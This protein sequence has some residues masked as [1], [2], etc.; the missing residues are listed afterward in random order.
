[1]TATTKRGVVLCHPHPQYGGDMHNPVVLA[2]AAALQDAGVATLRFN[3]RGVGASEGDYAGGRGEADDARGAVE[4]LRRRVGA[5]PIA[6]AGYSF[7][8]LVALRAGHDHAGVSHLAA[9]APPLSMFDVGFLSGCTKPKL[10]VLGDRD[11]YCPLSA[12]ERCLNGLAEPKQL[13]CV[14]GADHFFSGHEAS[15]AQ[16]VAGFLTSAQWPCEQSG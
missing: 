5:A 7:G 8:A 12:L 16:T 13:H 4:F 9:I 10:F 11:Q 2:T 3:F 14:P 6:L 1:M 15:I